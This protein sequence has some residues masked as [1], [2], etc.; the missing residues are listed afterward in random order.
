MMKDFIGPYAQQLLSI[1]QDCNKIK[2]PQADK[3]A[4]S[5][6]AIEEIARLRDRPLIYP[7]LPS[8]KGSGP[9]CEMIDGSVKLDLITGI[10][11]FLFGH[12]HPD[13]LLTALRAAVKATTM[14]GTL[15]PGKEYGQ[16]SQFI[17]EAANEYPREASELRG[18]FSSVW[19]TTCG[20]MANEL[21][22]KI[23]RQKKS[24]AYHIIAF[25]NCFTGR[26]TTMQELTD[27]PKYREGQ[28]L[29]DQVSYIDFFDEHQSLEKNIQLSLAQVDAL[30]AERPY[31][32]LTFEAV[33][34]EGGGFRSAPAE[35]WRALLTHCRSKNL[36]IWADEVQTF[37]R[38]G[39]P[40]AFQRFGLGKLVDIVSLAKPLHCGAVMWTPDF[41]PKAGLIAGTFAGS[42]VALALGA[43]ILEMLLREDFFGETGS[44]R[45][46]EEHVKIDWESRR[47]RLEQAGVKTG[48]VRVVGGMIAFE[49]LDGQA[50]TL[51]KFLAKLFAQGVIGFSA[52]RKPVM[53][54]FLP[55]VGVITHSQWS[56]G[57]DLVEK[58]LKE[59][60]REFHSA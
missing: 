18:H 8:G 24:P 51:K 16:L 36:G 11:V 19:L 1:V 22:L 17:L 46:F 45:E 59:F 34:G 27:E 52:G 50:E 58:T 21:A 9:F 5:Q 25:R 57:M 28:P 35:W 38:T 44:I 14:Q 31:C 23:L 4:A 10:G 42:T 30:L 54:R 56:T 6:S 43:K 20:T 7:M 29:F 55:P 40:F 12:G 47:E 15:M 37:G 48:A 49:V 39:E 33:Q 2:A 41:A 53:L 26:S 32:G 13:L 3:V 60:Q